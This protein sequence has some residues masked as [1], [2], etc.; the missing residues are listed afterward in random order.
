MFQ[1]LRQ[2]KELIAI[3]NKMV[4]QDLNEPN[5]DPFTELAMESIIAAREQSE[6]EMLNNQSLFP[7]TPI[8][9]NST[10][11]GF[12]R[13]DSINATPIHNPLKNITNH[14]K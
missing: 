9:M 12:N 3:L 1:L 8:H 11:V 6:Y 4:N 2:N 10:A 5:K 7:D 13:I 14:G